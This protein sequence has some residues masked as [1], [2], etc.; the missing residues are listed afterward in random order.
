MDSNQFLDNRVVKLW[1][2]HVSKEN[3]KAA[4]T[5]ADPT[6]YENLFPGLQDTKKT[7][8]FLQEE[9][10]QVYPAKSYPEMTVCVMMLLVKSFF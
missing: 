1:R 4:Q 6:E 5:L 2:E 9:R 7:E 3:P 8:Q 10:K